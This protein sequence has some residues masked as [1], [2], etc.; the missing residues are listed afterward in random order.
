MKIKTKIELSW[1]DIARCVR[2]ELKQ[3]GYIVDEKSMKYKIAEKT[4]EGIIITID[5]EPKIK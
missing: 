2:N 5:A 1:E 3:E 4:F